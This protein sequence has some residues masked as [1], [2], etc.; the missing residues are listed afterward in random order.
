MLL[1]VLFLSSLLVSWVRSLI[2]LFCRKSHICLCICC[3]ISFVM[4]LGPMLLSVGKV[5]FVIGVLFLLENGC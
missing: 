3:V 2:I 4:L 1:V 5:P